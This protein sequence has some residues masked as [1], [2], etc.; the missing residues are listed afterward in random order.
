[1]EKDE[2]EKKIVSAWLEL[3]P[4]ER[5]S[6]AWNRVALVTAETHFLTQCGS[7]GMPVAN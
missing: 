5:G 7:C 1:M 6:D 2:A 4:G 3:P